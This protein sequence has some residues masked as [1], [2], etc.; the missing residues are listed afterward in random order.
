M[1]EQVIVIG[2]WKDAR[3]HQITLQNFVADGA[4]FIPIFS[5][6]ATFGQQTRGSGFET[7]GIAVDR[8]FLQSILAGDEVLVLNP[9]GPAPVTLGVADLAGPGWAR[10]TRPA[11]A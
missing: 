10:L 9:G 2:R 3:S 6:E 11:P 8:A 7:S 4:S 1:D 5:D